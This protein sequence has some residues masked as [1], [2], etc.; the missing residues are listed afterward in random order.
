MGASVNLSTARR[1][2]ISSK[3][4]FNLHAANWTSRIPAR[5]AV[6]GR[7]PVVGQRAGSSGRESKVVLKCLMDVSQTDSFECM[8]TATS[9]W[10]EKIR[11]DGSRGCTL[12]TFRR[13]IPGNWSTVFASFVPS[14]CSPTT[15]YCCRDHA[16]KKHLYANCE[17]TST[18]SFIPLASPCASCRTSLDTMPL[19]GLCRENQNEP[20]QGPWNT[21][22]LSH[23]P[24]QRAA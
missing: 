2:R 4:I 21:G 17:T 16:Q 24:F 1:F 18:R 19:P 22:L 12:A 20:A 10:L 6:N 3:F 15:A 8:R 11:A 7:G 9:A 14:I 13:K 5:V 23:Q